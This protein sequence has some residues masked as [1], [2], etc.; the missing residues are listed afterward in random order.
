MPIESC[1]SAPIREISSR[2]ASSKTSIG[3]AFDA[4]HG[5]AELAHVRERRRAARGELGI[6]ALLLGR[7]LDDLG[8]VLLFRHRR[9]RVPTSPAGRMSD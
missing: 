7:V 6:E 5:I 8:V 2:S 3:R 9:R 4:Q 1:I